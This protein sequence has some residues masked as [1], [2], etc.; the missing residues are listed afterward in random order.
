MPKVLGQVHRSHA[1]LTQLPIKAVAVGEG[2]LKPREGIGQVGRFVGG[3]LENGGD[4]GGWLVPRR[5]VR[6]VRQM[7]I[8]AGHPTQCG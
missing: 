5:R 2:G 8:P 7:A 6:T 1:A 4:Q 3:L